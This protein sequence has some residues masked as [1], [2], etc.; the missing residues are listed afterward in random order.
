MKTTPA[1][2]T[3]GFIIRTADGGYM[4]R[5]YSATHEFVDYDILHYDMEVEILDDAMFYDDGAHQWI[6]YDDSYL[7]QIVDEILEE[8]EL[9]NGNS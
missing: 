1:K 7:N 5:V 2:G 3:R 6:D 8:D 9:K 4:F